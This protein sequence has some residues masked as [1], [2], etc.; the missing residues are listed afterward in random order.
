MSII[1]SVLSLSMSITGNSSSLSMAMSHSSAISAKRS[2]SNTVV[3]RLLAGGELMSM[4][5][6]F[7][8]VVSMVV[9]SSVASLESGAG[10]NC[11][12]GH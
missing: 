10:M 1:V 9:V 8:V 12:W 3:F 7:M 6:V 11:H 2:G 4:V 5:V